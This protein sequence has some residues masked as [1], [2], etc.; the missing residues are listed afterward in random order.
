MLGVG[1]RKPVL[2]VGGRMSETRAWRRRKETRAWSLHR[3][4]SHTSCF[5][6]VSRA[7]ERSEVGAGVTWIHDF[8][9]QRKVRGGGRGHMDP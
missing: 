6:L 9:S 8:Q 3:T 5:S 7:K 1:G 4:Q 2:G